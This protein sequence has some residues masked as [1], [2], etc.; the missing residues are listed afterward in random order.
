M[1][2][3]AQAP[4]STPGHELQLLLAR[5]EDHRP[6][7]EE[8]LDAGAIREPPKPTA[9][10]GRVEVPSWQ[11]SDADP[12]LLPAQRWG[13]IAP[14][15]ALGDLLVRAIADLIEHRRQEQRAPVKEYR[16]PPDMDAA[17]AVKWKKEVLEDPAVPK[18][19]RPW[20][21]LILGDLH[22][23]SVELQQ[24]LAHGSCVGRLH[25]GRP[26]GEPDLEGYTAY[27]KKVVAHELRTEVEEAPD[28][29][30]YTARDGSSAT[31]AG[32]RL[33][34]Q[35]SLEVMQTQWKAERPALDIVEVPYDAS[36]PEALLSA[37]AQ[38]R[39]GVMLSVSHG[40]G[41]PAHG[42]A[43]PE[44]QRST[45]GALSVGRGL[46]LTGEML[47][48]TPFLPGGM[49]F[50][51]ACF[52]AATPPASAFHAWLSHL[53]GKGLYPGKPESV[54][55]SLPRAGER[56]FLAAL[57]Q[58]LLANEQGP[59]AII[60]HS[61]LAWAFSFMDVEDPSKGRASRILSTLEVLANGSRAG[62]AHS[63]L[64]SSYREV[65]NDLTA[66][67][68]AQEEARLYGTPDP[69]DPARQGLRWM[70]RND[71]R[72]YLLLGDPAARLAV[73]PVE[74]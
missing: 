25:V 67:Y 28:L 2:P 44:Q 29:L 71:L 50:C 16:V 32:Q 9:L 70:L 19:E 1:S 13:V 68:Q 23:V 49:W 73:K 55:E 5:A 59:L 51:F 40:L 6:V 57:P 30:L 7:L 62:V 43:S 41:R 33:L 48:A 21:L 39:A 58:A 17:A 56:P 3:P 35:P 20:Y 45:Q 18:K 42:W 10:P 74:T 27:A 36:S 4:P 63:E 22:H 15:G 8:G 34:V 52:G 65:N 26:D 12:N 14:E 47:R 64:M 46:T 38:A 61:D 24:V 54:L 37:A 69:V 72:G 60:G 31:K 66:D 11:R 53:A